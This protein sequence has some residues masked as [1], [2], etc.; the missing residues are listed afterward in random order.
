MKKISNITILDPDPSYY[1]EHQ[2]CRECYQKEVK[3]LVEKYKGPSL[4]V[5]IQE[6]EKKLLYV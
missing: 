6:K 1:V 5:K 4:A 2:F 3:R